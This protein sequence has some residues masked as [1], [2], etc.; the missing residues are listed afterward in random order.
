M[1]LQLALC[2][3]STGLPLGALGSLAAQESIGATGGLPTA[4]K[5]EGLK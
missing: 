5:T 2:V 1:T 4:P 3:L